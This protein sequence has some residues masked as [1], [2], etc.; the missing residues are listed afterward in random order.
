MDTGKLLLAECLTHL[1]WLEHSATRAD[2]EHISI[3]CQE[4][5]Y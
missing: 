4:H 1:A 2:K 5:Y 3:A